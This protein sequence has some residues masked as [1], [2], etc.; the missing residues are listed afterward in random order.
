MIT[1]DDPLQNTD[2]ISSLEIIEQYV[3]EALVM[4]PNTMEIPMVLKRVLSSLTSV[5]L[6][7]DNQLYADAMVLQRVIL[8]HIAR[9]AHIKNNPDIAWDWKMMKYSHKPSVS[10]ILN[11]ILGDNM[12]YTFLSVFTH[13]DTF[14]LFLEDTKFDNMKLTEGTIQFSIIGSSLIM[15]TLL[16]EAYPAMKENILS[17]CWSLIPL[18]LTQLLNLST[19]YQY[20]SINDFTPYIPICQYRVFTMA[21]NSVCR[22]LTS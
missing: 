15:L 3:R 17:H 11:K 10:D 20:V 9:L 19:E 2:S 8:E 1:G 12:I 21:S 6:L 22:S 18:M 4:E 13:P 16:A 7:L 14:S 5:H